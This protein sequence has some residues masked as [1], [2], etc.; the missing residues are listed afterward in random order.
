M[1]VGFAG[2]PEFAARALGAIV[3]AGFDVPLVLTQPD[4][5]KGRGMKADPSPVKR[6]ALERGIA[7]AQPSS[8]K[9]RDAKAPLFAVPLDVLV[10]A[11]YGLILP[12]DVLDWPRH[13][14]LNIHA[15]LLPRWRGAAPIQRA[16][17]AG[18]AQTGISIMR[19]DAGLDTGPVVATAVVPVA[20]RETAQTLHDKLVVA[21]ASAMV[22]TL[23][24]LRREHRLDEVAQPAQGA[25]YASK[26]ERSEATIDW[27]EPAQTIDRKIRAFNP[28]PTARTT[29]A[30]EPIK[31]WNAEPA[32]GRFGAAGCV[33]QADARGIVVAC[34]QG[35]LVVREL[36][37]SGARRLTVAAFLAGHPVAPNAQL[38]T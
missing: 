19:M 3:A 36:Q 34:G 20:L 38:G 2:T 30:G 13:G 18:D 29:L 26:I 5:P 9:P 6:L 28:T 4:R 33:V 22:A 17:L 25:T 12:Q 24:Q 8:L 16:L 27:S 1:R 11:A 37:R 32:A 10:V 15:S 35:A 21:G 23:D 7:V 14:C 31:I